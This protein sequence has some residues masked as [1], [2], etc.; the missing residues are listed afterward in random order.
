MQH[1]TQL[2]KYTINGVIGEGAMG[3]VYKATDTVLQRKV[4]IKTLHRHLVEQGGGAALLAR[5]RNEALAAARLMHPNIVAVHDYGEHDFEPYIVME[6]VDG[7]TLSEPLRN[8][9]RFDESAIIGVMRQL[10][11]GLHYAHEQGVWHRDIKP[12]N[13]LL[14]AGGRLKIADF[15]IARIASMGL[16]QL[17]ST[18]GT[19]GHMAPEQYSGELVD[20][21]ADI[22]AAG[23]LLYLMLAQRPPF[24]GSSENVMFQTLNSEPL[25]PS[26]VHNSRRSSWFDALVGRAMAKR[27]EDRYATALEFKDALVN[28]FSRER[29]GAPGTAGEAASSAH[30]QGSGP[31]T[32]PGALAEFGESAISREAGFSSGRGTNTHPTAPFTNW[33]S[34]TLTHFETELAQ[35]IGPMARILVN[36]A[37]RS[38]QDVDGLRSTLANQIDTDLQRDQFLRRT[39]TR[40]G[41]RTGGSQAN[42]ARSG[43]G[44]NTSPVPA[45]FFEVKSNKDDTLLGEQSVRRAEAELARFLGPIARVMVARAA[46]RA[47]SREDFFHLLAQHVDEGAD[48]DKLLHGLRK[49]FK[50][51]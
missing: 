47:Q 38:S 26:R 9:V 25:P 22:F 17:S 35:L 37:A 36:R 11:D 2:S 28:Q 32:L 27:P 6:H 20:R 7:S 46:K 39:R 10:L 50:P 16:T 24:V 33:D 31:E 12:S 41:T 49:A 29:T 4:A 18:I 14:T 48:R 19:P 34:D 8:R 45:S 3:V 51:V 13:L 15:G 30:W 40:G 1:P 44:T 5:F 43:A 23:V 21:R 42:A